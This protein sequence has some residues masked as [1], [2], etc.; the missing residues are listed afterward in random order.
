MTRL[1][2]F[3]RSAAAALALIALVV[4]LPVALAGFGG[5]YL[6]DHVPSLAEI[7]TVL[8]RRDTGEVFLGALVVIGLGAWAVFAVSV[9]LEIVAL[10]RHRPVR[11]VRGL[12]WSRGIAAMLL[13]A[14]LVGTGGPVLT[15]AS[16]PLA[17]VLGPAP[18]AAVALPYATAA[19][20]T[21]QQETAQPGPT[22]RVRP[23]DSLWTIADRRLGDAGRWQELFDLNSGRVQSDGVA[24]TDPALV[25]PGWELTLPGDAAGHVVARGDT[26]SE[27]AEDELGSAAQWPALYERNKGVTQPDGR[28]LTDPDLI[29]P[30]W[31][32]TVDGAGAA[33]RGGPTTGPAAPTGLPAPA[34]SPAPTASGAP[35]SA[36]ATPIPA[37]RPAA[38]PPATAPAAVPAADGPDLGVLVAAGI[39]AL[40]AAGLLTVL[41][42][43]RFLSARRRRPGQR[44]AHSAAYGPAEVAL[45]AAEE[46]DTVELLDLAL[47]T[48]AAGPD[49]AAGE[50]PTLLAATVGG[51]RIGLRLARPQRP[52]GPFAPG[53][54]PVDWA[55]DPHAPLLDPEAAADI[56]AP[57]P[58]LVTLGRTRTGDLV[59]VDL[60]A[61]G[62]I[63]LTGD[64]DGIRE[65]LTALAVELAVSGWADHLDVTLVGFA[66]ELAEHLPDRLHHAT[67]LDRALDGFAGRAQQIRAALGDTAATA[68]EARGR[69][70]ADDAWIPS[71]ILTTTPVDAQQ[72]ERIRA[73]VEGSPRSSLA[74][75]IAAGDAGH[76]LPGPWQIDVPADPATP[77]PL[78]V[79]GGTP[80]M[81]QRCAAAAYRGVLADL[82]RVASTEQVPA[83]GYAGVPPEPGP[84]AARRGHSAVEI[85]R[86]LGLTDGGLT[87]GEPAADADWSGWDEPSEPDGFDD[88]LGLAEDLAVEVAE[89]A[90]DPPLDEPEPEHALGLDVEAS[91]EPFPAPTPARPAV[92][93]TTEGSD[94]PMLRLL[95]PIVID[96]VDPAQVADSKRNRLVELAAYLAL[97]PGRSGEEV[98]HALGGSRPWAAPTR[99][100]QMSRLR[101]WLGAG[102]DGEQLV[103]PVVDGIGYRL[104]PTM[105]CDWLTFQQLTRRGIN[106]RGVDPDV[107]ERALD[108]VGGQPFTGAPAGRYGWADLVR[109]EMLATITD[110]AHSL[111]V[112]YLERGE[113]QRARSAVH[114]GLT[115]DPVS[116]L[117]YRDLCR[118]EWLAG[119][120]GAIEEI[121]RRIRHIAEDLDVDPEPETTD[122]LAQMLDPRRRTAQANRAAVHGG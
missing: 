8:T 81:V 100:S 20:V 70:V 59:L 6:P 47:R 18:D 41:V 90:P 115:A 112:T 96:G 32:L 5:P 118:V 106:P 38:D 113:S 75:V 3:V 89:P 37:Q 105:R 27:I 12:S 116:E 78:A 46:P 31:R 73:L 114:R 17:T 33:N 121:A 34:A 39:S 54:T 21:A 9:V 111:A 72:Q 104:S 7:G 58:A 79:L 61:A 2:R 91:D 93:L 22:Y 120:L 56:P 82:A 50:L 53:A 45:R 84:P 14:A 16:A 26:L 107:L 36:P 77:V 97:H 57:Y 42:G 43:R 60:E 119:D 10:V 86:D 85:E 55:Y 1:S 67:D 80:I 24:L 51:G 74:A 122:L 49:A 94:V 65:V 25:R 13:S 64:P 98:S 109:H 95:G 30:G 88:D 11:R 48:L 108:L 87:D 71:I 63:T 23:G 35:S 117:L 101:N 92:P 40:A 44:M 52:A 66:G 29:L 68:Q 4:G 69:G 83:P 19:A 28:T 62:A 103:A 110:V 15:T 102:P 76:R 99:Q